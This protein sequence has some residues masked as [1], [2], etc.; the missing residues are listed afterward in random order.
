MCSRGAAIASVLKPGD[1]LL[2]VN[3]HSLV[4]VSH[5]QAVRT[6]REAPAGRVLLRVL[7]ADIDDVGTYDMTRGV[8]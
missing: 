5:V 1:E 6:L 3:E 4:G 8:E 2:S 7:L